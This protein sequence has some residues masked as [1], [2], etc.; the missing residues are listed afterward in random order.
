MDRLGMMVD[1]S[2]PSK[3]AMLQAAALSKAPI[4]ASHSAVRALANHSRNL[5]DEQLLAI[6]QNGGI[7]QVVAFSTYLVAEPP[8]NARARQAAMVSLRAESSLPAFGAVPES[9]SNPCPLE[10]SQANPTNPT[11]ALP[12]DGL[13]PA[14]RADYDRR[15]SAIQT[16]PSPRRAT[17][18]DLVDHIDYVVKLIGLDHVGISSDFDGGGIEAWTSVSETFNVTLELVRRGYGESD[19][20]KLWG[21][22]LLRVWREVEAVAQQ[23][24]GEST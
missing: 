8:V 9:G 5:D 6:K 2:H 15:L 10:T 7:V 3:A 20:A 11:T 1:I 12:A 17:V 14:R 21:G 4:I 18:S 24:Q 19:I 22:N 23:L 16:Y 13:T